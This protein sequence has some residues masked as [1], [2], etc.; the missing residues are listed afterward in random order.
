MLPM[1]S[2]RLDR[3]GHEIT[4][5]PMINVLTSAGREID[6]DGLEKLGF[7]RDVVHWGVLARSR[8]MCFQ[9]ATSTL[10]APGVRI[11]TGYLMRSLWSSLCTFPCPR[12][13]SG[14]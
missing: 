3:A 7:N 2:L 13:S 9:I 8:P 1:V 14:G 11:L 6:C 10:L 12:L 4:E 5:H